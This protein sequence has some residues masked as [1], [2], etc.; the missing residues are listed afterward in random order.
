MEQQQSFSHGLLYSITPD[1][2]SELRVGG[3]NGQDEFD[4]DESASQGENLSFS[5]TTLSF[6]KITAAKWGLLRRNS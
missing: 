2:F 1:L 5:E 3:S 4:W 6:L